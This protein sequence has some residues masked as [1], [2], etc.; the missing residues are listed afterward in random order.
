MM[1]KIVMTT[2][3]VMMAMMVMTRLPLPLSSHMS[4]YIGTCST[5]Q[6]SL[7]PTTASAL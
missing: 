3:M 6:A 5:A 7:T 2:M 4:S 1:G